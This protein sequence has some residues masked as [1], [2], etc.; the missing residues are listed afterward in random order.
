MGESEVF[1]LPLAKSDHRGL[2]VEVRERVPAGR[3]RS[4]QKSKPFRY[5]NMWKSHG[6]HMDFVNQTWDPGSGSFDLAAASSALKSLQ[7]SLK[8]W[9]REV[10]GS[11]KMQVRELRAELE[12]EQS[13]TLYRGPTDKERTVVAK[14]ADVLAREETME[15]QRS[16]ISWLRDGDRNT[17]F[18]QAKARAR[19]QTYRIKILK[20]DLG[21]EYTAQ[22]DLERLAVE[23][24]QKPVSGTGKLTTRADMQTCTVEGDTSYVRY[25]REALYS[26]RGGGG[27][28]LNG[29]KQG[30][31]C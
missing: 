20:D 31:G 9:D 26:A 22:D 18:F 29:S 10:F 8:T 21:Q 11:V 14:L 3:R 17:E 28:F 1:H 13:S 6:E 23:F 16:W 19:N 4:R 27:P 5:E 24:Y 25:S 7:S 12:E 2:L 15:R 30:P